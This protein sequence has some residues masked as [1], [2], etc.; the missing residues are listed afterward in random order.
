QIRLPDYRDYLKL[1]TRWAVQPVQL[2]RHLDEV[3]PHIV[4]FSSHGSDRS[5]IIPQND[6]GQ[7]EMVNPEHLRPRRCLPPPVRPGR[8]P[9]PHP[10]PLQ[11]PLPGA[12]PAEAGA[13]AA[14]AA[15]RHARLTAADALPVRGASA[16]AP[17]LFLRPPGVAFAPME[18]DDT[19]SLFPVKG[20]PVSRHSSR[21]VTLP[22]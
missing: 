7:A 18:T 20:E 5:E 13:A 10:G 14:V 22:S 15:G 4:H 19:T 3:R 9:Q 1:E 17:G 8:G 2:I 16:I 21:Q 6:A 11:G 12:V